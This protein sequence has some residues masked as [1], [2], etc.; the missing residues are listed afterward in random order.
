MTSLKKCDRLKFKNWELL[1]LF[2]FLNKIYEHEFNVCEE[3]SIDNF[4]DVVGGH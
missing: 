2:L 3:A 1:Y 4:V